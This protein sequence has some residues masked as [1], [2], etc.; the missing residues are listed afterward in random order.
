MAASIVVDRISKRYRIGRWLPS[1]RGAFTRSKGASPEEYHWALQDVSFALEPGEALGIVGPNG[2]GK[3]TILK[4][5][6]RVTTPTSGSVKINGR[7]AALIELGAGFHPDLTGRENIFLNGAILGMRRAEIRSRLEQIVDFS[8]IEAYLDTPVK[9]YSSGMY[10]RLGFAIAV[11][12][13]PDVLLVDEVLAVGDYAFQQKCYA[14]MDE[15]RTQGTALLFVSHNMD[16]V[17][18]VCSKGVVMYR[19]QAA[20][21]GS[22]VAAIAAYSD[23][24]R[25]AAKARRVAVPSEGGLSERVMTFDAEIVNVR[26]I[27]E[28]GA[29]VTMLQSGATATVL[30][31]VHFSRDVHEPIF[32]CFLRTTEGHT[33]YD[34]TT[35]W[36]N[37]ATPSYS[38]GERCQVAYR[39]TFPLLTG[40]YELGVD[41]AS[42]NFSHY[43]D[44]L[45][46]ALSIHVVHEGKQRGIVDMAADVA[47]ESMN[48]E[49]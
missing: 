32:S 46:R 35:R 49:A 6:S 12:V 17:R 41:V 33:V 2:A 16:V 28:S 43:Y 30:I 48:S 18:R 22:A 4:I 11:H 44:R 37:I 13:N 47:F 34:T 14:H 45:E 27:D 31:D 23:I 1:L 9:R 19:G 24:I 39:L 25:Q 3:T 10:A 8:G 15:L 42:T 20:F 29:S 7:F 21:Q 40:E 36:M 38:A 26:L 5:L